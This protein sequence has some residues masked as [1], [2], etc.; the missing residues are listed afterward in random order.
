M[1]LFLWLCAE[2]PSVAGCTHAH[3]S[4][5]LCRQPH[6]PRAS[7]W[8]RVACLLQT[9]PYWLYLQVKIG[10]ENRKWCVGFCW[11]FLT[12]NSYMELENWWV[13]YTRKSNITN[14]SNLS[15][16]KGFVDLQEP[17]AWSWFPFRRCGLRWIRLP[18]VTQEV[19]GNTRNKI[20]IVWVLVHS[21]IL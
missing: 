17:L 5:L 21:W 10:K 9:S 12:K 1:I 18:K 7:C 2:Q 4:Q 8:V 6:W 19:N 16:M 3:V 13:H 15:L 20:Q 11:V 14:S